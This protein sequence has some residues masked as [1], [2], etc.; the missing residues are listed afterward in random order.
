MGT[1]AISV[2]PLSQA[3]SAIAASILPL[4]YQELNLSTVTTLIALCP[5]PLVSSV[6]M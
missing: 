4:L 3:A 6:P 5:F 2:Q 1:P